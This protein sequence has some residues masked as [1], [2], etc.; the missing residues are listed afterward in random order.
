[1]SARVVLRMYRNYLLHFS[2]VTVEL[3]FKNTIILL[4][5]IVRNHVPYTNFVTDDEI[6][7][8]LT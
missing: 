2:N 7:G 5:N 1:M 4:Y 3:N 8:D 6:Q